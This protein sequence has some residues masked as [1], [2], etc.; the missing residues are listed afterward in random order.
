M[1]YLL[2]PIGAHF[3]DRDL[4]SLTERF[5]IRAD[6]GYRLH[7]VFEVTQPAGCLGG[8]AV[9]TYVAVYEKRDEYKP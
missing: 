6:D 9:T 8:R 3:S 7:S 1:R 5:N 4:A 2:E